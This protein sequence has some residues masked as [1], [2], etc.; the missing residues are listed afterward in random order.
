[1]RILIILAGSAASYP[2][3]QLPS[4][5]EARRNVLPE[6]VQPG[7]TV[8][9]D[10]LSDSAPVSR[11]GGRNSNGTLALL[12]PAIIE[13]V[14]RAEAE[15]YDAVVQYG[16]LDPGTESARH[17]VRIPVIGTGRAGLLTAAA[18]GDHIGGMVY[19]EHSCTVVNRMIRA[20]GLEQLVVG[21][22]A[23]GIPPMEMRARADELFE[24][25][26]SISRE[27]IDEHGA[28]VIL[29]LGL[30]MTP[31]V[32]PAAR[33]AAAV[34]APVV[35]GLLAGLRMAESMVLMGVSQ[36]PLAYAPARMS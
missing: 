20:Y 1:M 35:D 8:D 10:T 15:G 24:R 17:F 19:Q 28:Q 14:V 21:V 3:G 30:S 9:V 29:P 36:S 4:S 27:L 5:L 2:A 25:M 13:R 23:V 7:T 12:T 18:L 26:V 11:A 16:M 32:I 34:N 22:R 33:L 6:Y 31:S